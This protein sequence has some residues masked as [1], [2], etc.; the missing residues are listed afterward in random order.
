MKAAALGLWLESIDVNSDLAQRNGYLQADTNGVRRR[1]NASSYAIFLNELVAGLKTP[2]RLKACPTTQA[3]LTTQAGPGTR[4]WTGWFLAALLLVLAGCG[5][6]GT[7][8]SGRLVYLQRGEPRTFNPMFVL[9]DASHEVV[10]RMHADLIHINRETQQVEPALAESWTALPGDNGFRL[11]LRRNVR[12]S[13]GQPFDADDVVF[14]FQAHLDEKVNSPQR[15]LL[16]VQGR[17][18]RVRKVDSYTVDF[19]FGGP[20]GPA[21]RIFDSIAILPRHLLEGAYKSGQLPGRWGLQTPPQAMAGLGPFRLKNYQAGE[22]LLLE[23]NPYYW[24][25]DGEG[26]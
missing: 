6:S 5:G 2:R 21:E 13:D 10:W 7:G 25:K 4:R 22:G 20:Y 26:E 16:L 18:L 3:C 24:K 17:P 1:E 8:G 23:R 11:K 12:F 15:G 9:D 19:D 14:T